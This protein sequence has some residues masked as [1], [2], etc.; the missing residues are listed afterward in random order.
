MS[1][2]HTKY[3]CFKILLK[4]WVCNDISRQLIRGLQ[5]SDGKDL[6]PSAMRECPM[7]NIQ[8]NFNNPSHM[9]RIC[10]M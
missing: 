4:S 5:S 3:K 1:T 7:S 9:Y 6:E 8:Y 10:C 2:C